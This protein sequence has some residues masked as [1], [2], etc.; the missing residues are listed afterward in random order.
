[1]PKPVTE[2]PWLGLRD[3]VYNIFWYEAATKRT[4]RLGL[5]T[6]DASEAAARLAAFITTGYAKAVSPHGLTVEAALDHYWDEHVERN[7]RDKE[8]AGFAVKHLV[9]FFGDAQLSSIDKTACRAFVEARR[10]GAVNGTKV[11]FA[12]ARRELIVLK[13][14]AQHALGERRIAADAMPRFEL[15]AEERRAGVVPWFTREELA[16]L[17]DRARS[18]VELAGMLGQAER[19]TRYQRL[20]DFMTLAYWWGA[21]KASVAELE[22]SQVHFS[23]GLVNLHKDHDPVTKKRRGIVPIFPEQQ[24]TL[25]RLVANAAG[26]WL[27]GRD[28]DPYKPFH[29]MCQALGLPK[30][31][32]KPHSLR[33]SRAT[34]MLMD[35]EP[36]YKVAK[37]LHDTVGTVERVYGHFSHDWQLR[38]S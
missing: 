13:A 10:K 11:G 2:V 5:R 24:A 17:F 3:G 34:H 38:S 6:R 27:F 32:A 18:G 29:D 30:A 16:K 37:L 22:T 21:R 26:G 19:A 36:I 15:P 35:G 20:L 7:V 33:H 8:R 25:E 1:M 9:E 31:K 28:Y 14:A 23:E 12:T 4:K